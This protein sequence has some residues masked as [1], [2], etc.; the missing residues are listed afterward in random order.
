MDCGV[1]INEQGVEKHTEK[2]LAPQ[3]YLGRN[4][5]ASEGGR[6]NGERNPGKG[7]RALGIALRY[8]RQTQEPT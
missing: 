6:Y 4:R 3:N 5:R 2:A 8:K 7:R 1:A